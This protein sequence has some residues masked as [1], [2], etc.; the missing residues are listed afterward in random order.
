MYGET[1]EI[2]N[3]K[4]RAALHFKLSPLVCIG[5]TLSERDAGREEVVVATQLER[6]LAELT[7]NDLMR[8]ILSYEPVW[9]IGTGHTATPKQ[10]QQMQAFI[11]QWVSRKFDSNTADKLQ[12]LYGGSVKPDN[13]SELMQEA[14]IDG[15]LVGG[16]SLEAESFARIVNYER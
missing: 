8:I 16:A 15:A 13:I 3:R 4:I 9:A 1:D 10:A 14:D 2:V 12:I 11:R 7:A 6:S 5:E